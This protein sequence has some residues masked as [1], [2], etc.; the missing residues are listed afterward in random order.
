[1]G[2]SQNL[3]QAALGTKHGKEGVIKEVLSDLG[4]AVFVPDGFPSDSF[5]TF[6]GEIQ[7]PGN[8]LETAVLKARKA[9]EITGLRFGLASEG[10]YGPHPIVPMVALGRELVVL[11]DLENDLLVEGW[12]MGTKTNYQTRW[13]KSLEE[14]RAFAMKIGFPE[15]GLIIQ[16]SP[17]NHRDQLKGVCSWEQLEQSISEL[18]RAGQRPFLQSDMRASYNPTRMEAVRLAA[19]DL[20]QSYQTLCPSCRAPGFRVRD[21]VKGLPCDYCGLPTDMVSAELL[22]CRRCDFQESRPIPGREKA[23]STYC[24]FCNP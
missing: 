23:S 14:A 9:A 2:N 16:A 15:H 17:N 24:N 19:I 1:M 4:F 20:A 13:V 22:G 21:V 7:R 6:T 12:W 3:V 10:S 18:V 5:G 11:L 8:Q